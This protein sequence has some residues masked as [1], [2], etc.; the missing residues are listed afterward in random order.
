VNHDDLDERVTV[1]NLSLGDVVTIPNTN[2]PAHARVVGISD[3]TPGAGWQVRFFDVTD[4]A[5]N[6]LHSSTFCLNTERTVVRH[7]RGDVPEHEVTRKSMFG[8]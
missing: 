4:P 3:P 6:E 7:R 5:T 2:A 1:R 8:G